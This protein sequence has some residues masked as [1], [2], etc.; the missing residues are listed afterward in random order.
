[1]FS[2]ISM[3]RLWLLG[4]KAG[5]RILPCKSFYSPKVPNSIYNKARG[6][7]AM[8]HY[9]DN[10]RAH[11]SCFAHLLLEQCIWCQSSACFLWLQGCG[12][13]SCSSLPQQNHRLCQHRTFLEKGD[14]KLVQPDPGGQRKHAAK[15]HTKVAITEACFSAML[16]DMHSSATM[17]MSVSAC[18][19]LNFS[20]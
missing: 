17:I 4:A 8:R 5:L 3:V 20:E 12:S 14:R 2:T 19:H 15:G 9:L 1:M 18:I 16:H 10:T 11:G 7:T 6:K 13:A